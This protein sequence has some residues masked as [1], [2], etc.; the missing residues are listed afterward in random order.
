MNI[1]TMQTIE[2]R[3]FAETGEFACIGVVIYSVTERYFAYRICKTPNLDRIRNRICGFFPE[4]PVEVF[5]RSLAYIKMEL[6]RVERIVNAKQGDLFVSISSIIHHLCRPRENIIR[7]GA[8]SV[9]L[10]A[11][12]KQALD[13]RFNEVVM[14]GFVDGEGLYIQ[15]MK[16]EIKA[17][18]ARAKIKCSYDYKIKARYG[19]DI[20]IPFF[21]D[22]CDV[23][24]ALR[25]LDLKRTK[26]QDVVEQMLRWQYNA[27]MIQERLPGTVIECPTRFPALNSEAYTAAN[28]MILSNEGLFQCHEY[29]AN[30]LN[31][32]CQRIA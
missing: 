13:E 10:S 7:F 27:R 4:M 22:R 25:P 11:N 18:F 26:A 30:W 31:G 9:V 6:R 5:N 32:Y 21:F 28:D 29:S 3:P 8:C 24:Q 16:R 1:Y 15:R 20:T 14:R 23:R 2:F 19:Y 12:P 17:Q